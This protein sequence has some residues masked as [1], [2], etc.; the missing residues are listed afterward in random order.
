MKKY[1]L[2]LT[3]TSLLYIACTKSKDIEA[4]PNPSIQLGEDVKVISKFISDNNLAVT[5]LAGTSIYY[6]IVDSGNINLRPTTSSF[7]T[8]K[9][10]GHLLNG[11]TFTYQDSA[12]FALRYALPGFQLGLPLIGKGGKIRL[13]LPS[14]YAYDR[15]GSNNK[16]VAPNQVVDFDVELLD[17]K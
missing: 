4:L 6:H 15:Q 11:S 1:I 14:G 7:I 13:I 8:V 16:L 3:V 17:I 10:T 5:N 2:L 12:K 9:Y